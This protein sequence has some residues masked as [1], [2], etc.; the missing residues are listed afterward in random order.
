MWLVVMTGETR[1]IQSEMMFSP[2]DEV[3]CDDECFTVT[4]TIIGT[5]QV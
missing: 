5:Q 4:L 3:E 2:T 1:E